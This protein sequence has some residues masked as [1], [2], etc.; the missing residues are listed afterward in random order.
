SEDAEHIGLPHRS[1]FIEGSVAR[2]CHL[3]VLLERQIAL[4]GIR[5]G[6]I[7]DKQVEAAK[8]LADAL[9]CGG[10]RNPIR[11][12]ELKGDGALSHLLGCGLAALEITRPD[13][14]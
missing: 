5:D 13:Q 9:R 1:Y 2:E 6:R 8:L 14:H 10:D 3:R 12:V 11:Y 4:P 7:I